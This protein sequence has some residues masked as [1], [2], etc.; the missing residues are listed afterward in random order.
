[1]FRKPLKCFLT[2][3][4]GVPREAPC[5][6]IRSNNK[7]ALKGQVEITIKWGFRIMN[8]D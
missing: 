4:G 8:L 2:S 5:H 3:A 6:C 1:M 7:K